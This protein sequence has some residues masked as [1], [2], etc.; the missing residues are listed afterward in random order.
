MN[1]SYRTATSSAL[2]EF[3]DVPAGQPTDNVP[4]LDLLGAVDQTVPELTVRLY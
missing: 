3:T 2:Y 1:Y 4:S